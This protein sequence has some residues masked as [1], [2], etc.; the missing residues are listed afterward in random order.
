[1]INGY[2]VDGLKREGHMLKLDAGKTRGFVISG[3]ERELLKLL[4]LPQ[5]TYRKKENVVRLPETIVVWKNIRKINFSVKTRKAKT[6]M[7]EIARRYLVQK[8]KI[9]HAEIHFKKSGETLIDAPLKTVPMLHQAQ[10]Y[11]FC[12]T[13]EGS[14]L[15][16][17]QGTG[18]TLVAIALSPQHKVVLIVCPKAVRPSW[19]NEFKKHA[20][21]PFKARVDK[22]PA[23]CNDNTTKVIITNYDKVKNNLAY[24]KSIKPDLLI[25]DEAHR[26]KSRKAQTTKACISLAKGIKHKLIMSGTPFGKCISEVWSQYKIINPDIFGSNFTQFKER[27]LVM[28]GYMGY[29]VTG[30]KNEDEFTE[31]LHQNCFRVLKDECVDLPPISYQKRYITPNNK[32]KNTY[33]QLEKEL[34]LG[35]DTDQVTVADNMSLQMKLRQLVGGAVKTDGHGLEHISTQKISELQDVIEHANHKVIVYFSF[36]HEMEDAI[37]MCISMNIGYLELRGST[38]EN[39]KNNFESRFQTDQSIKVA[40]IQIQTGAEGLNLMSADTVVFYSPSFSF[41]RYSQARDRAYRIGQVNPV[42]IVFLMMENTIDYHVVEIL[43]QNS[44]TM[45]KFL[46]HKREYTC[47]KT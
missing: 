19:I 46:D 9:R 21:F 15:Y 35:F 38:S 23:L 37:K 24:L 7:S 30:F 4:S 5:A 43:E 16:A 1:M 31:K 12:N 36:N 29:Q 32:T 10:A 25:L 26:V 47:E 14:A 13:L 45:H 11:G 17:D 20:A 33:K 22:L 44:D 34:Y 6:K 18:K 27:Y 41:I 3:S 2:L 40:L 8:K 28:G 42:N 39:D